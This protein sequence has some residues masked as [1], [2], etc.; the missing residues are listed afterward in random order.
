[1]KSTVSFDISSS[2]ALIAALH[3]YN[4]RI[5]WQSNASLSSEVSYVSYRDLILWTAARKWYLVNSTPI[6]FT[7][8]PRWNCFKEPKVA[9]T[10][11]TESGR[12]T[13]RQSTATPSELPTP[14]R[15]DLVIIKHQISDSAGWCKMPG[16]SCKTFVQFL[17]TARASRWSSEGEFVQPVLQTEFFFLIPFFLSATALISRTLR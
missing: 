12:T 15:N 8:T 11:D 5:G 6:S 16:R 14:G 9:N 10:V 2:T 17:V 7:N 3:T 1:M 4:M 13:C